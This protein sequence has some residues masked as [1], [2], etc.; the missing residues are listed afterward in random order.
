MDDPE[1]LVTP[2]RRGRGSFLYQKSYMYSDQPDIET[3][4]ERNSWLEN[5]T[6]TR[7]HCPEDESTETRNCECLTCC[8]LLDSCLIFTKKEKEGDFDLYLALQ[9]DLVPAMF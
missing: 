6:E 9:Q 2:K 3:A 7:G 5:E 1:P 4:L 8:S